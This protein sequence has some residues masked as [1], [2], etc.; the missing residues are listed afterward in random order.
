MTNRFELPKK[1]ESLQALRFI[2]AMCITVYH[3][4]GLSGDCRFDFSHAVYLFYMISGF[5]VLLSTE[6]AEKQKH[7][8]LRRLIRIL[9]LYWGLTAATFIAGNIVP[10][11]I[12]YR[13]TVAQLLM[14][15]FFIPF[16]RDTAAAGSALRPIVGLGHTLQMEMLFY[17]LF[18]IAML[19]SR[20]YRGL[21]CAV[22][23]A[24]VAAIG[25]FLPTKN[26]VIHFYTANPYVWASF[27]I[28]IAL[29]GLFRFLSGKGISLKY[30]AVPAS[31]TV[32][33][34][35]ALA[36]VTLTCDRSV[37]F[38][39]LMLTIVFCAGLV[40]SSCGLKTPGILVKLGNVSFS[41]YL[42]H[43]YTVTLAARLLHIDSFS[44]VN[45]LAALLVSAATWG[46]SWVSWYLIENKLTRRLTSLLIRTDGIERQV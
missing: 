43:Y 27:I 38:D 32:A 40:W 15:M 31:V 28:G 46:L 6:R 41:Y 25:V 22:F 12:G 10:D 39:I 2:G 7:F 34:S 44:I 5:V 4:S 36:A 24:G 14:S 26:P 45:V 3:F 20:K 19:I 29:Y 13:P 1:I 37:W 33:L 11:F 42:L 23:C 8:L 16:R 18:L 35:L 9:P 21:I 30:R 17:V